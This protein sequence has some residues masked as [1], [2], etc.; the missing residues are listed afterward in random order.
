MNIFK[1]KEKKIRLKLVFSML[2]TVFSIFG[3]IFVVI[4]FTNYIDS[5]NLLRFR[6]IDWVAFAF[7]ALI[8]AF[9]N[10]ALVIAWRNIVKFLGTKIPFSQAIYIYGMSQLAKYVPGNIFHLAGRQ[11]LGMAAGL[12]GWVLVKSSV[13]EL[14]LIALVGALFGLL[15]LPLWLKGFSI[16]VAFLLFA[17]TFISITFM[18]RHYIS[19]DIGSALCWQMFFLLLSGLI[20]VGIL[21]ILSLNM[22]SIKMILGFVGAFII[23]WLAGLVTPGAP[24]GVGVRELVLIFFLKDII[25]EADL[26]LAVIIGRLITIMGDFVFAIICTLNKVFPRNFN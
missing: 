22:L 15:V 24:A 26:L 2:G 13:L 5:I 23:A 4:R 25:N 12:P 1:K 7:L 10:L 3:V 21:Y 16:V 14:G 17:F 18:V 9:D 6:Y 11:A 19:K 8:Y 20:F